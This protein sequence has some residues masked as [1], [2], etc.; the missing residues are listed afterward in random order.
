MKKI[1]AID[2][3]Y[4][5]VSL[6]DIFPINNDEK[7]QV[8]NL[9]FYDGTIDCY[10]PKCNQISVFQ[11]QNNNP[12]EK[13]FRGHCFPINDASNWSTNIEESVFTI[14]KT[15][16]CSRDSSHVLDFYI[17]I[18]RG[19]LQK[20]GQ[21]PS[22]ADLNSFG[23][24]KFKKLL[25][26]EY[27]SEF[28]RGI[29]LFSHGVGVGSFVYLRRIIEN[30]IIKPAYEDAKKIDGWNDTDYQRL[31]VTEKIKK[32]KDFLPDYLVE[33]SAI[34]SIVSKGIHELTEDECSHYFPV[35]RECLEFVLTDLLA[36]QKTAEKKAELAKQIGK[37]AGEVKHSGANNK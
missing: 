9:I 33:N 35:L 34:Y 7:E 20:I 15:F 10:C 32:L 12:T 36:K 11:A 6:Y 1:P 31:R 18:S 4:I 17:L 8:F 13:N 22:I 30:F 27:Y 28:N 25:G 23:I 16:C 3:F 37:I 26:K 5:N 2:E 21:H 29:G 19:T 14:L 24:N